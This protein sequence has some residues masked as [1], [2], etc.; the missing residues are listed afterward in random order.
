[1]G[2]AIGSCVLVCLLVL[3]GCSGLIYGNERSDGSAA[4]VTPAPVPAIEEAE[5]LAPGLTTDGVRNAST[6]ADAHNETLRNRSFTERTSLVFR[7]S[8]GT[9]YRELNR[10]TRVSETGGRFHYVVRRGTWMRS[11]RSS[12]PPSRRFELWSD[13][14]RTT[15]R[16]DTLVNGTRQYYEISSR[17]EELYQRWFTEPGGGR[18]ALLLNGSDTRLT[19]RPNRSDV[20]LYRVVATDLPDRWLSTVDGPAPPRNAT[21]SLFVSPRGFVHRYEIRYDTATDDGTPLTV[22]QQV[23]YSEIGVTT[24]PR[25]SWYG[26]V[27]NR[28]N[29]TGSS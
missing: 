8:N 16:A 29:A 1:M 23:H 17:E 24:V 27:I 11:D 2:R 10:T 15:L 21:L 26:E 20:Q 14:D 19:E 28:T 5:R 9:A 12:R 25:P 18:L 3:A 22:T 7:Y 13:G 6:L 4:S